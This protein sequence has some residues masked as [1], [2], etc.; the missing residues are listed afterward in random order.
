MNRY[1]QLAM[2]HWARFLPHRYSRIENPNS[3]FSELGNRIQDEIEDL[4]QDLAGD[5]PPG[6]EYLQKVGRLNAAR[7]QAEEQIL[8][9]QVL[10]PAEPG[11]EMDETEPEPTTPSDGWAPVREDPTHPV[12]QQ[13]TNGDSPT[14]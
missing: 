3:Y 7:M 11:T 6:E 12:W 5:D 1:G 9:E 10:L 8:R 14:S 13:M 2:E 4:A